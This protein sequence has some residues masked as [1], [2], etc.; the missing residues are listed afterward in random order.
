VHLNRLVRVVGVVTKRTQVFP[1]IKSVTYECTGCKGLMGPYDEEEGGGLM[2]RPDACTHCERNA[3][4]RI[5][6][7]GGG[8]GCACVC[9]NQVAVGGR[10]SVRV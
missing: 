5:N 2:Q 6:Q 3:P 1:Q 9:L 8:G 10:V 4:L 7:V